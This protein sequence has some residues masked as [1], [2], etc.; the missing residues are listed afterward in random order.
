VEITHPISEACGHALSK[1][2]QHRWSRF[3]FYFICRE[4]NM[5]E[6]P[7]SFPVWPVLLYRHVRTGPIVV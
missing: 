7:G 1:A 5:V 2:G 3:T 4:G 6:H